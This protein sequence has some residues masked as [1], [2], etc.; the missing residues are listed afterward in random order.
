MVYISNEIQVKQ[1][2]ILQCGVCNVMNFTAV[3][4]YVK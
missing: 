2:M 3:E 1:G 4:S